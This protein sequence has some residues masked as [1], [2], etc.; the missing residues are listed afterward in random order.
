M[1]LFIV[2]VCNKTYSLDRTCARINY[3]IIIFITSLRHITTS[4]CQASV[5]CDIFL[6]FIYDK[7]KG[8]Q[9]CAN[10][11]SLLAN[12]LQSLKT[13]YDFIRTKNDYYL[14]YTKAYFSRFR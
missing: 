7:E 14:V 3:V 4:S 12:V 11:F 9:N 10:Q 2:S 8:K 5:S 13:W 6:F 1:D